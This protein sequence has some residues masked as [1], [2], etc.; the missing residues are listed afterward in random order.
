MRSA[1]VAC[2]AAMQRGGSVSWLLIVW[3]QPVLRES[4]AALCLQGGWRQVVEAPDTAQAMLVIGET[5]PAAIL[6]DAALLAENAGVALALRQSAPRARLV[7]L[8]SSASVDLSRLRQCGAT[9]VVR[10][11]QRGADLLAAL[12]GGAAVSVPIPTALSA[13][14]REVLRLL[15]AGRRSRDA[16]QMLG[17]SPKTV[18][19]YRSRLKTKIGA[20]H[21]P[22]LVKYA[23]RTGLT[24]IDG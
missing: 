20:D 2:G 22:D 24:T 11:E 23:I 14:E 4:L 7:A 18:E 8:A 1:L 21:L 17:I 9:A 6:I 13:R 16:A 12:R 19:T 5:P 15:A 3:P 10:S